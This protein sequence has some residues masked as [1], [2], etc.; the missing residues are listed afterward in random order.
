MTY[1][2]KPFAASALIFDTPVAELNKVHKSVSLAGKLQALVNC[3]SIVSAVLR[4]AP[5][6]ALSTLR[7]VTG[8]SAAG[9]VEH[10]TSGSAGAGST[11]SHQS[12]TPGP[13]SSATVPAAVIRTDHSSGADDYMPVLCYTM[14]L[15]N[16]VRFLSNLQFVQVLHPN[17]MAHKGFVDALVAVKLLVGLAP[18]IAPAVSVPSVPAASA[19]PNPPAPQVAPV[20]PAAAAAAVAALQAPA[21][22]PHALR[23]Q[24]ISMGFE[25]GDVVAGVYSLPR[26]HTTLLLH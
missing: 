2:S 26:D 24:L 14:L 7:R 16:P 23:D 8:G 21:L 12:A 4:H 13:P 22:S 18:R 11:E 25:Q 3:R 19:A 6:T 1:N 9:N 10:S 5:Y 15:A 20:A 17:C